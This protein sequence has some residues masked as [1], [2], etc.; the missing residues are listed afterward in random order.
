VWQGLD[1]ATGA[2]ASAIWIARPAAGHTLVF[3]DVDGRPVEVRPAA[4]PHEG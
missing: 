4:A 3:V 1:A 2:V